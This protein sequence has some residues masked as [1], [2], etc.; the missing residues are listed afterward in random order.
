MTVV[1][2]TNVLVSAALKNRNPELVLR[3]I[4]SQPGWDWVVSTEILAEYKT[5]LARQKFGFSPDLLHQWLTWLETVT[6]L[7][8]VPGTL[9]YP[10]DPTDAKFLACALATQANWLITGDHDFT[11][12]RKL[13][14]TTILSVSQFKALVCDV[15]S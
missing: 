10:P 5:V 12:A 4:V 6:V 8:D 3:W 13:I 2:D 9:P 7:V 11:Q 1:I 14:T 15:L